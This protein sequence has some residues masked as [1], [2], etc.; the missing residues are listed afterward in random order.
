[1]KVLLPKWNKLFIEIRDEDYL[2]STP[3]GDQTI[4]EMDHRVFPNVHFSRLHMVVVRAHVFPCIEVL[5]W[6]IIHDD[7]K[8]CIINDEQR[9]CVG[10]FLPLEISNCYKLP[11]PK[12]LLNKDYVTTF[13]HQHDVVKIMASWWKEDNKFFNWFA[14]GWYTMTSL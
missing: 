11:E 5:A 13:H 12:V 10:T 3:N 14:G 9:Q 7:N 6:I 2:T 4:R 1:M 8:N